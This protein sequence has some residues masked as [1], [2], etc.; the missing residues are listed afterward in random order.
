MALRSLEEKAALSDRMAKGARERGHRVSARSFAAQAD[1]AR[2]YAA[3]I[4]DVIMR[5]G[6]V[7]TETATQ[8]DVAPR[9]V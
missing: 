2:V 8:Q 6:V 1:E 4:R 7:E 5:S 9:P 3:V